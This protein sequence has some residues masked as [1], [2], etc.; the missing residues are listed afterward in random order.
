[1]FD[2]SVVPEPVPGEGGGGG[3]LLMPAEHPP[4][5]EQRHEECSAVESGL[6]GGMAGG[7]AAK[8]DHIVVLSDSA[9]L[10]I[11]TG[12]GVGHKSANFLASCS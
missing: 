5:V 8:G 2:L 9:S 1:M 11:W 4:H 6:T 3:G 7:D 10:P 12:L